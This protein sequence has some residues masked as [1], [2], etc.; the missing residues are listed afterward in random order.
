MGAV[1]ILPYLTR[2]RINSRIY[3]LFLLRV[4]ALTAIAEFFPNVLRQ[5]VVIEATQ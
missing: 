4:I 1:Y 2:Y 5:V 3:V